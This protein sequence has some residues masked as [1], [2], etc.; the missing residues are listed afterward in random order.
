MIGLAMGDRQNQHAGFAV[1]LGADGG[2]DGAGPIFLAFLVALEMFSMPQIAVTD[3]ETRDR[4][5]ER[6]W[7]RQIGVEMGVFVRHVCGA[8]GF[9]PF[10]REF[11]RQADAPVAALEPLPFF[12]RHDHQGVMTVFGDDDRLMTGFVAQRAEGLL[13]LAGGDADGLHDEISNLDIS[14]KTEIFSRTTMAWVR[15]IY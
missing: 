9:D 12:R 3:D 5:G 1:L 8:D 11:G 6:R 4:F 10:T 14:S 2:D 13:K 7:L 15:A